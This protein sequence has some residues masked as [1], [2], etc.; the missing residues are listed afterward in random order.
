MH[1]I[2]VSDDSNFFEY[3][4]PKLSLRK[5]DEIYKFNFEKFKSNLDLFKA[6]LVII[7]SENSESKTLDLLEGIK[8]MA[9][10]VFAYN[11]NPKFMLEAY[12]KGMNEYISLLISDEELQA[13]LVPLFIHVSMLERNLQFREVLN[14]NK[15]LLKDSDTFTNYNSILDAEIEKI[16][17]KSQS[18]VLVAIS[19]LEKDKIKIKPIELEMIISKN[20]RKTDIFI[21]YAINRYFLILHN[22]NIDLAKKIIDNIITKI[23]DK[24]FTGYAN[25]L[26]KKRQQ[27]V[28][29]VLN[30]LHESIKY[31]QYFMRTEKNPIKE[32]GSSNE[33]FKIFKQEFHKKIEQII[34][35]AFY[36]VQQKYN[37]SMEYLIKINVDSDT[38]ILQIATK[39]KVGEFKIT[40]P[41]LTKINIDINYTNALKNSKDKAEIKRITFDPKE[42]EFGIL[43]DLL[44][45]FIEDFIKGE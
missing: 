41:G 10:L 36:H 15:L 30:R 6:S 19:T 2:L 34:I 33:N 5:C 44:E 17:M 16:N 45:R 24:I 40:T 38:K 7:N 8:E 35:P 23:P 4:V 31:D 28:D 9:T 29:E 14:N 13:K 22:V 27:V 32:L 20:I 39:N 11:E 25:I 43:C 12:Q 18:A 21:K 26:S 42:L 3:I 37:N 1:I